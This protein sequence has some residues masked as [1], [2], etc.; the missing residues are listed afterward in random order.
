ML[1]YLVAELNRLQLMD[2]FPGNSVG[3]ATTN[4]AAELE[5]AKKPEKSRV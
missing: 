3:F 4:A 5:D 2:L 1:D